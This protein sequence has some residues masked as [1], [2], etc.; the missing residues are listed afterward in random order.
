MRSLLF[1]FMFCFVY[2]Q[3]YPVEPGKGLVFASHETK[4][5]NRTS[6][7]LT[8]ESKIKFKEYF[9]LEFDF[10]L[11]RDRQ[12]FGYIFRIILNESANIDLLIHKPDNQNLSYFLSSSDLI[13]NKVGEVTKDITNEFKHVKIE[14]CK[15]ENKLKLH[16]DTVYTELD[17]PLDKSNKADLY[18][19]ISQH[20]KYTSYDT[21][22]FILK[23]VV[24]SLTPSKPKY[25][26]TLGKHTNDDIVYDELN[27]KKAKVSN[28]D[29]L[30][31][32]HTRWNLRKSLTEFSTIYPVFDD[33]QTM[34]LITEKSVIAFNIKKNTSLSYNYPDSIDLTKSVQNFSWDPYSAKLFYYNFQK[35]PPFISY[36]NFE[37]SSWEREAINE[38]R[39]TQWMQHSKIVLPAD[40]TFLRIFGYGYHKY[41]S[42]IDLYS[43]TNKNLKKIDLSTRIEPRYL[44]SLG[45]NDSI[46]YIYGGVGNKSGEQ[47]HGSYIFNDLF[48]IDL[49]DF[50]I[51]KAW[52]KETSNKSTIAAGNILINDSLY[53]LGLMYNPVK[54]SNSLRLSKINLEKY[55]LKH[56]ADTLPYCFKDTDSHANLYF[57]EDNSELYAAIVYKNENNKYEFNLYSIAYP[58]INLEDAI[59][60]ESRGWFSYIRLILLIILLLTLLLLLWGFLKRR[61]KFNCISFEKADHV[62]DGEECKLSTGIYLLGGFYVIDKDG[63]DITKEFTPIMRRILALIILESKHSENGISNSRLKE[64]FWS[65]K[66]EKSAR[67]NRSVNIRKIRLL[68]GKIGKFDLVYNSNW[69]IENEEDIYCDYVEVIDLLKTMS[70]FKE[71]GFLEI[72][73]K[74]SRGSLLPD[75][76]DEYFDIYKADYTDL[77]L[78]TFT[79]TYE[80]KEVS[81]NPQLTILL[82]D[83]ILMLDILNEFAIKIKCQSLIKSGRSGSARSVFDRFVNEYELMIGKEFPKKFHQFMS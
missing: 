11:K 83:A 71:E 44:S 3:L 63:N 16:I 42:S 52:S 54:Y 58:V 29:W 74:I 46:L 26:W 61:Q 53:A 13:Y 19:G 10:K 45:L 37:E 64:L 48:K 82:A 56:L 24:I 55:E 49:R 9:S 41:N 2:S 75:I 62:I 31:D 67:N 50:S 39:P 12:C 57:S 47:T 4:Q 15:N 30:I 70:S 18:F 72:L 36:F 81:S 76:Q 23:D 1:L 79:K 20:I 35:T 22:P 38:E 5:E 59:Q 51:S 32:R 21:P 33:K 78:D 8:S 66:S 77:I 34:Y 6:L 28:P 65:D 25:H 17:Y 60:S 7:H 68:I 43:F 73:K 14:F 69:R 80:N 40:S 27:N